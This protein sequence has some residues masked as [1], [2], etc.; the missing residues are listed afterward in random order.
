MHNCNTTCRPTDE[1]SVSHINLSIT[2]KCNA[3][4]IYTT[5]WTYA[6]LQR[7]VVQKC[8]N[9]NFLEQDDITKLFSKCIMTFET[10]KETI[11]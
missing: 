7:R 9:D 6:N 5:T 10:R 3:K 1:Y 2:S 11:Q 8:K 4:L